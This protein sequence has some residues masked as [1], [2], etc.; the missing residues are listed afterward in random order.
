MATPAASA[1]LDRPVMLGDYPAGG[2]AYFE[3]PRV[4]DTTRWAGYVGAFAWSY[5]GG[6]GLSHW[7]AVAPAFADWVRDQWAETSGTG[8]APGP[9]SDWGR[10]GLYRAGPLVWG[11]E[12]PAAA[13]SAVSR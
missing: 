12:P 4:L 1:N 2:S 11:P 5:W 10:V 7:Q 8:S 3:L 13:A 6:D 9:L